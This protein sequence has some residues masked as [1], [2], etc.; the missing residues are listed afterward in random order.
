[1]LLITA[2]I[3][4]VATQHYGGP[5][6]GQGSEH[7]ERRLD[8]GVPAPHQHPCA[9][10]DRDL[11]ARPE[12][13]SR[14]RITPTPGSPVGTRRI[15]SPSDGVL[16]ATAIRPSAATEPFEAATA[17]ADSAPAVLPPPMTLIKS[18]RA[19]PADQVEGK[20]R[21]LIDPG[22]RVLVRAAA[23]RRRE[24]SRR[25][26]TTRLGHPLLEELEGGRAR[27]RACDPIRHTGPGSAWS[28]RAVF[29]GR[30][31]SAGKGLPAR[32]AAGRAVDDDRG[33]ARRTICLISGWRSSCCLSQ[34][35][36]RTSRGPKH[37]AEP[38]TYA[39]CAGQQASHPCTTSRRRICW[40]ERAPRP[41]AAPCPCPRRLSGKAGLGLSA[42][43]PTTQRL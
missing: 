34:S 12:L 37:R 21:R 5:S 4:R 26:T 2:R 13:T 43:S 36:I 14:W 28:V 7:T 33:T 16:P 29:A 25:V 24:P 35:K 10:H 3:S 19:C 20:L 39:T 23:R 11:F 42:Q 9:P 32:P 15:S 41:G 6:R 31:A 30:S 18:A 40:D 8:R 38:L 1:M 17:K 22:E 27:P